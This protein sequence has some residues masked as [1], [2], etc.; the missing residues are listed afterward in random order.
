MFV[1]KTLWLNNI[2]TGTVMNMKIAMLVICVE[3]IIYLLSYNLHDCTFNNSH[4]GD[5]LAHPYLFP[6]G[7]F[8]Y[9]VREYPIFL[10][11]NII[12]RDF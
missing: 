12:I 1:N 7:K 2:K 9:Q 8:G 5:E 4:F 3:A 11:L 6:T 10:Q